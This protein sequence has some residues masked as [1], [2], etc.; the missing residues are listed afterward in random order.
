MYK[1]MAFTNIN[2]TLVREMTTA[3][4]PLPPNVITHLTKDT[5]HEH[6]KNNQTAFIV[7]FGAE[8]CGPCKKIDPLV[9]QWVT[10]MPPEIK[11]AIIDIDDNFEIYAFLKSKKMANSIPTILCYHSGNEGWVADDFVIGANENEVNLFFQRCLDL[12]R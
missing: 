10:K 11:C 7:K 8:W 4:I 12:V 2:K 6:L 9:Y 5:F 3:E 1:K